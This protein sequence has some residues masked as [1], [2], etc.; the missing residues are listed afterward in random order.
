MK[1]NKKIQNKLILSLIIIFAI[2]VFGSLNAQAR[3]VRVIKNFR[4]KSWDYVWTEFARKETRKRY[5]MNL[6]WPS[7]RERIVVRS[8]L[9]NSNIDP[10]SGFGKTYEGTRNTFDNDGQPGY[11]YAVI[12][13][14]EYTWD[15]VAYISGSW[16]PDDR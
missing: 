1:E 11:K 5:V 14:R 13:T 15:D 10:R 16:S 6:D 8:Q 7:G 3:E 12:L 2:I 9:I 4:I